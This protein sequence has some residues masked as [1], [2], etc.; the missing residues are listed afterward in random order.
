M[1]SPAEA[2]RPAITDLDS[3]PSDYLLDAQQLAAIIGCSIAHVR[4]LYSDLTPVRV[5]GLVRWRAESVRNYLRS[6]EKSG[7]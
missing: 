6:L 1:A 7:S 2:D 3:L 4:R 5:R